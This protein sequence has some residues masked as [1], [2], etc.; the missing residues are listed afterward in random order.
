MGQRS[1]GRAIQSAVAAH[2]RRPNPPPSDGHRP[3]ETDEEPKPLGQ[4]A[5]EIIEDA[6]QI[7]ERRL[8]RSI[9]GDAVTSFIGGMSICF[10][11][12]AMAW[13][14]ASVGNEASPSVGHLVAA[15]A[16]PV[17]FVILLIG[18]SELFT[19]NFLLPVTGVIDG[20]GS[21][22]Q[23]LSLWGISLVFNLL[24]ALVFAFLMS[25]PGVL[26]DGPA[27]RVID[28]ADHVVHYPF[29]TAF[30]KALFA[31]WL[32]TILTWLLL[33]AEGMGPRLLIMWLIGTLLVLAEFTHVIISAAEIFMAMLL[34]APITAT[35]WL[36]Q[37]FVPVLVG[38]LVG[39]VIFVTLLQYVQAQYARR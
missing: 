3:A 19:E 26:P 8:E 4:E 24:G 31:G 35:D 2:E 32:M 20:H 11:V 22:R 14:G 5:P 33:A 28:L 13:A 29:W 37:V 34:G 30:V 9:I 1:D 12:L 23:L 6:S 36:G 17:G 15:L 16:Y 7:G 27:Q 38:N 18:K 21:I 39:G 25:R 10:G